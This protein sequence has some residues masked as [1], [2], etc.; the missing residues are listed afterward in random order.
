M[1]RSTAQLETFAEHEITSYFYKYHYFI[2]FLSF[3]FKRTL[4]DLIKN[5]NLV[6]NP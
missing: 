2:S 4:Q 3:I 5:P 6:L 1:E